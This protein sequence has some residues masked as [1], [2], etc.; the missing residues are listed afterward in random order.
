[1][2]KTAP[3]KVMSKIELYYVTIQYE[4][5]I[6]YFMYKEG[7][8][9]DAEKIREVI[10]YAEKLSNRKPYVTFSDV[11]ANMSITE[12]G[13]SIVDDLKNMPLF[14]GTAALVKNSAY[15][16]AVN[17]MSTFRKKKYPFHAFTSEQRA[18]EWLKSLSLD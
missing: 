7:T 3:A 1:M 6:V 16:F 14:R 17:F 8:E 10:S 11:R 18:V 13:K 2:S 15:S 5:P 4:K 9:L 12:E